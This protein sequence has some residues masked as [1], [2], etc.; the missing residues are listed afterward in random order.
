MAFD[1][2]ARPRSAALWSHL[3]GITNAPPKHHHTQRRRRARTKRWPNINMIN[4]AL[5]AVLKRARV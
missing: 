1:A 5:N 4:T 3:T 2:Q